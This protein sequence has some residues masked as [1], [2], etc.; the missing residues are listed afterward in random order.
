MQC[1]ALGILLPQQ[2]PTRPSGGEPVIGR[3]Q[4]PRSPA[5]QHARK[6][7]YHQTQARG[8]CCSRRISFSDADL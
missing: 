4:A 3:R 2:Y 6:H 5:P 1:I 7:H 8:R